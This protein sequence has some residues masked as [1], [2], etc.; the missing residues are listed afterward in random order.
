MTLNLSTQE[1]V[2]GANRALPPEWLQEQVEQI[3][4]QAFGYFTGGRDGFTITIEAKDRATELAEVIK[5]LFIKSDT[6]TVF[7][8]EVVTPEVDKALE[9]QG[10]LPFGVD[11]T[12]GRL[13][14]SVQVEAPEDWVKDQVVMVIDEVTPYFV[15]DR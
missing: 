13:I 3:L 12:A 6:Y 11:L 10:V 5:D 9:D 2:D 7:F 8:D 1:I 15:G 4:D 14:S